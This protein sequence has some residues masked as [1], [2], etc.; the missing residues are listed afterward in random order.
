MSNYSKT[1][2][3]A[4]KDSLPSGD[5][6]KIIRGSEFET[7]FDNIATAIATKADA[8][9]PTFTGTVTIDG[10]TVNGNTTLGNAATDTVT[11]T[12][13]IASNLIPSADDTYNLGASGAEWNDLYVDG[14][15]YIDTIDGFATTGDVTFG[16]NDKA[17]FGAG[18]DLQI[19]H[20]GSNSRIHDSGTGNLILRGTN[21]SI[22]DSSGFDYITAV[23]NGDGGT[24]RLF[25]NNAEKLETTSTGVDVT[26]S[27]SADGLT[28]DTGATV[29]SGSIANAP[30]GDGVHLGLAS[31]YAQMQLNGSAGGIIDFST[32]GTDSIGRILYDQASD[33]MRFDT[34][35]AER[36]RI[37]SSG[38]VGIGTSSPSAG[39]QVHA[40]SAPRLWITSDGSNPS[41]AGALRFAEQQNGGAYFEFLHNGSANTLKLT[42]TGGDIITFD[43][44]TLNVGIGTTSPSYVLDLQNATGGALA[45]FKDS[46]SS[47]NGIVI[48]GDT[49]AGWVGNN[50][51]T[52][53]EGIY[54]QNSLNAMRMYT[55]GSERMRIDSSGNVLVGK[56]STGAVN[57]GVELN[58][59]G[60]VTA[61]VDGAE[62]AFFNRKTSDGGIVQ[63]RK[64]NSTV[65]NIGVN[66]SN[67]YFAS[68]EFGVKP[69][70]VGLVST[71]TSGVAQDGAEDLGG[72]SFRWKDL[73]LSGGAYL[74]GTAAANKLD[75]YEEGTWTPVYTPQTGSFTTMTMDVVHAKYTKVGNAVHVSCQ[76]RTSDVDLGTAAGSLSISGLPFTSSVLT[77]LAVGVS[78]QFDGD[79]PQFAFVSSNTITLQYK[80]SISATTSSVSVND[81]TT[82]TAS[83]KNSLII[84]GTYYTTA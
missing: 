21:L 55:N 36:M 33:Y 37:D 11:V 68:S 9:D 20:D 30:T 60:Y 54:Y 12:A 82:G 5:S 8:A 39:L 48:A 40:T 56:T 65:G 41:D 35:Y 70:S 72:S 67:A 3:F 38:N 46:D 2:D 58:S 15:A 62:A 28:V 83:N 27:I 24:V 43:R 64:D 69:T 45:R 47:Y 4:A 6:G 19:F 53:G 29:I 71:N 13:D 78:N 74:G 51:L 52:A 7:E 10:L 79:D 77:A 25:Y 23:D 14:V 31:N 57:V 1:T 18:S 63:F 84:T 22:Q 76:I 42:S 17:I 34:N 26:G 44:D 75:D 50:A 16:D 80:A 81:L 49:A 66:S 32:S 61:S 59:S 73:Y